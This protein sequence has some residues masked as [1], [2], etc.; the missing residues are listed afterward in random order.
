MP[1]LYPHLVLGNTLFHGDNL[2]LLRDYRAAIS[3]ERDPPVKP[4]RDFNARFTDNRVPRCIGRQRWETF[5][6]HPAAINTV[7][8][9]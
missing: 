3:V 9:G 5:C 7:I 1:A 6:P 4:T 8:M 2:E